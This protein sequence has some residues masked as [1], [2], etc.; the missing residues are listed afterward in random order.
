[1]NYLSTCKKL[2]LF[3]VFLGLANAALS[4][5]TA[6]TE[7]NSTKWANKKA[8]QNGLTINLHPSVNKVVF[9]QQYHKNKVVWDKVFAFMRD[10]SLVNLKPGK[11]I[12]D[13]NNA[14][15]SITEAP[16]KEFEQS[17]WESHR[18]Y[19]D[20]QYVIKGKE[21]IGVSPIAVATVT[22]PYDEKKDGANYTAEGK[23]YI[24][25]PKSF[26][27]FFPD[28]VHRP[29]IKVDGYDTV[30]KLVIKIKMAD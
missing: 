10:S 30:K 9:A 11:Y 3:F 20:L 4:Q 1:M 18:R 5:D 7:K 19:I 23:Y 21:K 28:D 15:A 13:G 14:I 2:L 16:S 29:N 25:D 12:I 17:T 24:A 27:L 22:K 26:F 6:W 8:W